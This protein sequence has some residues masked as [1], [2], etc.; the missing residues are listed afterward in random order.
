MARVRFGKLLIQIPCFNEEGQIEATLRELPRQVPGFDSVEVLVVDDGST[1]RTAEVARRAGADHIV[2]FPNNRGL[3]KAFMAGIDACLRLGA[4]VIVNTDADNQYSGADIQKLV[5]PILLG[6]AEMVVGD[7]DPRNVRHFG[8]PKRLLQHYGSWVVRQLS[9][10]DIPDA[11]SGF[12]AFS[13]DAALRLNVMSDFTYTL[14][15]LIQAGKKKLPVTH[16]PVA[17]RPVRRS[18]KLFQSTWSYVKRSASTILRIYAMYEPLKVFSYIGGALVLVGSAI[19]ARFVYYYAIGEG[20]GHVQSLL[21]TTIL[22]IIGFFT[23]LVGMMAD[24]IGGNRALLEDV[25]YRLRRMELDRVAE[26]ESRRTE[27][28]PELQRVEGGRP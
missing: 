8:L 4:D 6:Q 16:V 22:V 10:T 17:S 7:R 12:R 9:G 1:D 27:S 26:A 23:I 15:T 18:S 20:G 2:R 24:L 28:R 19:G 13:R 14:E 21:L 25:L 11:T 5:R 3:A